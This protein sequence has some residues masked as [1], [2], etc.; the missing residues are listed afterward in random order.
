MP[1]YYPE[2]NIPLRE[3]YT[4]RSL[5]KINAILH[6]ASPVW[7]DINLTYDGNG[8]LTQ[9]VFKA[10]GSVIQTTNLTYTNNNLTRVQRS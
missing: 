1:D 5:Q 9:A 7:D 8:N 10:G 4:E 2:N 3:D 6:A